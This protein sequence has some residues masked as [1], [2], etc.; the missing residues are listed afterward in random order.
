MA[1]TNKYLC[2]KF[3]IIY[4]TRAIVIRGLYFFNPLFES[5]KRYFKELFF[6]KILA[7]CMVS[8]Q[9]RFLINSGL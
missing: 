2:T 6:C 7:L 3:D 1:A 9:E 5:Q 8:I 4:R